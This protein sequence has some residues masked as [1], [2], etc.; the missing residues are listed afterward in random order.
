MKDTVLLRQVRDLG[1]RAGVRHP[2]VLVWDTH[3]R[4]MNAFAVGAL[5]RRKTIILTDKLID[6]LTREELLAVA[7]HEFAHHKYWHLSFL[8]LATFSALIWS[9]YCIGLLHLNPESPYV[10][11]F[12]LVIMLSLFGVV[13][14]IFERQADAFSAFDQSKSEGS[15]TVTE[16]AA[17]NMS[18][19]LQA[20]AFS[21]NINLDRDDPLHGSI[22]TRQEYL[23]QLVGCPIKKVPI[24]RTVRFVKIGIILSLVL[25]FI[26]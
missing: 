10:Q 14:R 13:S 21:Q 17:K 11:F 12:Q 1:E 15:S 8:L 2:N 20:L 3:G 16:Q 26:V 5:F 9:N 6:N 7:R 4:L 24:N 19:S 25:G 18:S 22:Q 23:E